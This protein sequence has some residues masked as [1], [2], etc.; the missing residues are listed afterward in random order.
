MKTHETPYIIGLLFFVLSVIIMLVILFLKLVYDVGPWGWASLVCIILFTSG[1]Q[2]A[3][4]G[5]IGEYIS[6]IMVEVK[7]RPLYIIRKMHTFA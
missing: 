6:R 5:L 3:F 4:I 1:I 7:G 2:F